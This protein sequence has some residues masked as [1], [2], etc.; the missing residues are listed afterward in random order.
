M[1]VVSIWA[2]TA[3]RTSLVE[4][5]SSPGISSMPIMPPSSR[6]VRLRRL[7]TLGD[8]GGHQRLADSGEQHLAVLE[9]P[10]R[11]DGHDLVGPGIG[12]LRPD[13]RVGH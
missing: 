4:A 8:R 11:G 3:A 5:G 2:P 6:T 13:P 7:A 10:A 1:A 9:E 12:V